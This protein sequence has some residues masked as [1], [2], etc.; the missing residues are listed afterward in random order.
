VPQL[1]Q[2]FLYLDTKYG[3]MHNMT[4]CAPVYRDLPASQ[5]RRAALALLNHMRIAVPART[6]RSD[7]PASLIILCNWTSDR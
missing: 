3:L 4:M 2:R 6:E 5:L 1:A 7:T